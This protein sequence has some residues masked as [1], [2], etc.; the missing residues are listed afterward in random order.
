MHLKL[1]HFPWN[2]WNCLF[3]KTSL[4]YDYDATNR[5]INSENLFLFFQVYNSANFFLINTF[6]LLNRIFPV[7]EFLEL[8]F[9]L[10]TFCHYSFENIFWNLFLSSSNNSKNSFR[11]TNFKFFCCVM[12]SWYI[13]AWYFWGTISEKRK[14]N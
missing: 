8:I 10:I 9:S 5:V 3:T 13:S 1:E 11:V 14:I 7:N 6:E 4:D 2:T 12:S